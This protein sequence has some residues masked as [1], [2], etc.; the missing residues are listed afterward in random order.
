MKENTKERLLGSQEKVNIHSEIVRFT[1]HDLGIVFDERKSDRV[2]FYPVEPGAS[3]HKH[4]KNTNKNDRQISILVTEDESQFIIGDGIIIN[5]ETNEALV[6]PEGE[7]LPDI[8]FGEKWGVNGL[9]ETVSSAK[10]LLV[11]RGRGEVLGFR[12]T[13]SESP[14]DAARVAL[15]V[16]REKIDRAVR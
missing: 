1:N 15:A 14:F 2:S 7:I 12:D 5:A 10:A 4:I 13:D 6:K 16:K 9:F 8:V 11:Y 3:R